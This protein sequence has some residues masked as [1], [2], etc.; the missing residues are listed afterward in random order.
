MATRNNTASAPAGASS[1]PIR[2][3]IDQLS[4]AI[5]IANKATHHLLEQLTDEIWRLPVSVRPTGGLKLLAFPSDRRTA[6]IQTIV[7]ATG[8]SIG[9][10][11]AQV[12]N[13]AATFRGLLS[14]DAL[15]EELRDIGATVK[16]NPLADAIADQQLRVGRLGETLRS[17][18]ENPDATGMVPHVVRLAADSADQIA[19]ALQSIHDGVAQA[20]EPGESASAPAEGAVDGID[21]LL[22]RML[23]IVSHLQC[24][25]RIL[26]DLQNVPVELQPA[27]IVLHRAMQD[28]GRLHADLDEWDATHGTA[29]GEWVRS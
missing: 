22:H 16:Y 20:E 1:G 28:L 26:Y 18:G 13:L 25:D 5:P 11:T 15:A 23:D 19:L 21:E 6:V 27:A 3:L 24:A 29:A 2:A 10:A 12:D 8:L 17:L 7:D 4:D 14:T 9:E